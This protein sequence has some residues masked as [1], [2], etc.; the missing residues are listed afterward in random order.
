LTTTKNKPSRILGIDPGLAS[1]GYGCIESCGQQ[2]RRITHGVIH[3]D[4]AGSLPERLASLSRGIRALIADLKPDE[5]AVEELFF[6]R[7]VTTA[8]SVSHARGVILLALAELLVPISEYKP[9]Q[10]KSAICGSGR[11]D[12]DAVQR[13]VRMLLGLSEI[14]R[15]DDAADG[16][17]IALCHAHNLP[18][19]KFL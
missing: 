19:K 17:A 16:L 3:T 10:V 12:K 14:P 9:A 11:A 13:M 1:V 6:G 2:L 18:L 5:A 7:N 8:I 4:P 15:P